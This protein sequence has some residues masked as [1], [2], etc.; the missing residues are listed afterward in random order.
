MKK[1]SFVNLLT[2]AARL[3]DSGNSESLS[4]ILETKKQ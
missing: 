2:A 1:T 4:R 3:S